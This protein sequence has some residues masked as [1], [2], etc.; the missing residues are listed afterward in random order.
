MAIE[1][2][3][4]GIY[5]VDSGYVRP[6][7]DAIHL[8]VH[9][10]RV[11]IV[12]TATRRSVPAVMAALEE[13]GLQP[14][15]VDYVL[16]THV[17]LDHAGGAGAL[18]QRLPNA[19]LT[20]HPRGERH[21]IDPTQLWSATAQI[22]G[23]E[24]AEQ[25]YGEPVPVPAERIVQTPEG[26]TVALA[27]RTLEFFDTPGHA[28]H[29]VVIRDTHT[30]HLFTGDTFG[31]SYREF[32]IDGRAFIF[33]ASTPTQFDAAALQR[34]IDRILL[35]APEAVYLTHYA[36]VRDVPR[37]GAR[38]KH[39]IDC[40]AEIALAATGQGA[41]RLQQIEP[42]MTQLLTDELRA[43]GV[44]WPEERI[45][46]MLDADIRLNSAGLLDWLDS[47]DRYEAAR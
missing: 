17:H 14:T 13:L 8:L 2:F 1:G 47:R 37:L 29:H 34:S 41:D 5:A 16:L 19:V 36:Q 42:A 43:H 46:Q 18:L 15:Q 22:Y 31:V 30:G 9:R 40:Y 11:A 45:R 35:L 4:H 7:F 26:A 21:M 39:L 38:M 12:D 3:G 20:V 32:D 33:P 28:R 24:Q 10:S 27:G 23:S 44:G 25:M 6:Q